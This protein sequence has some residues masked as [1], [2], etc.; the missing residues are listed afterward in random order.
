MGGEQNRL[1]KKKKRNQFSNLRE[2]GGMPCGIKSKLTRENFGSAL[3]W[4]G[5]SLKHSSKL[6]LRADEERF[7]SAV[8]RAKNPQ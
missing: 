5:V 2:N 4:C 3:Q 7:P 8:S 6:L 1:K